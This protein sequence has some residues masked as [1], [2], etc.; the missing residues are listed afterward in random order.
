MAP[1]IGRIVHYNDK[2][3]SSGEA[4]IKAAIIT[5]VHSEVCVNLTVF[6]GRSQEYATSVIRKGCAEDRE[7]Y[8]TWDW[9][10]RE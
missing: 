4:E 2:D 10:P 8:S 9:P 3:N 7:G 6:S 1:T 5:E